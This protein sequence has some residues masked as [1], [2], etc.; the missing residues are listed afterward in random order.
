MEQHAVPQH[1]SAYQFKLVGDMTL[2]QFFQLAGG[3]LVSLMLYASPL[4]PLIK[5]P[6]ILFFALLGVALA[7]LPFEDRPLEKW[8][9]AFFKSIYS[10]TLYFWKRTEKPIDYFQEEAPAPSEKVIAQGG[11]AGLKTY[12][13]ETPQAR[14]A[15]FTKL[16]GAER[17]FLAKTLQLFKGGEE[18]MVIPQTSPTPFVPEVS[19]PQKPQ[20][21][22]APT[23]EAKLYAVAPTLAGQA[24]MGGIEA[25]FSLGAAPPN[26]PS[27]PNT[28]TGQVMDA[29][30]KIIEAAIME[31]RDA[32]GRPVRAFKT[33]KLGHFIIVTPLA[34]G[35]YEIITE[36]EGYIF[37]TVTFEATGTIIPPI[38]IRAKSVPQPVT[39]QPMNTQTAVQPAAI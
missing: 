38:A 24:P 23:E 13:S 37:D 35:R 2:R 26:P 15:F 6:G 8:I 25:Q 1:V 27:T 20:A 22:V 21:P 31:I 3:L 7:F 17:D 10:P 36:K 18:K 4:H 39:N 14:F 12:L 11:E 32:N 16:E 28:I 19:P 33:N 9:V 30:G 34:N 29:N 5:W